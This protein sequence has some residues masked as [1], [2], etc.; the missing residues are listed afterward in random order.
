MGKQLSIIS[1]LHTKTKRD[2]IERMLDEKVACMNK[3]KEYNYDFW[4]GDRKYGYGGYH[5][6]G[7]WKIVAEEIIKTY[8][9]PK[10]AK[11]LD[12]GCGKA[13][14]LYEL[15]R[16]LPESDIFGFDISNYAINNAKDEIKTELFNYDAQAPYPFGDDYFDFVFSIMT[17]HNLKIFGLKTALQEMDRVGKKKYIAVESYRNSQELFNLQ[18]WALTCESFFSPEEWIWI[19]HEYHYHGDFEFIYFE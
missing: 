7:R 3:A 19:M 17:L 8:Q 16:L 9:L 13:H 11:I 15:K 14:L 12:V 4:D 2:Y 6:D 10:D 5:Y 18:C 1:K